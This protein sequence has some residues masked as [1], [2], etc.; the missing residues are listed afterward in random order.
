MIPSSELQ[1]HITKVFPEAFIFICKYVRSSGFKSR[2]QDS[3]FKLK[4]TYCTKKSPEIL[5]FYLQLNKRIKTQGF[6]NTP[7]TKTFLAQ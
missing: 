2:W 6:D 7:E 4:K 3:K 1:R 5:G